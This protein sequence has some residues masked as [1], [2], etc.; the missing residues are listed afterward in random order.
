MKPPSAKSPPPTFMHWFGRQVGHVKKAIR[1][2]V[3]RQVVY[4]QDKVEEH[5]HPADSSIT[6]RRTTTDEVIVRGDDV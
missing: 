1:T 5:P 3:G 2:Q 4:R 6:L